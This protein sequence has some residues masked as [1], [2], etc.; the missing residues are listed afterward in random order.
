MK[1]QPLVYIFII[2]WN[3]KKISV[4]CLSS[5]FKI[6]QYSN[7]KVI[8]IDNGS[9]DDS[10]QDILKLKLDIEIM[11]NKENIGYAPAINA[12]WRYCLDKYNP[13]YVCNMN[14]DIIITQKEWLDLMV[15]SLEK[16]KEYGIC[17]NR[18]LF[19]D[20]RDQLLF[21]EL[22]FD[23]TD[24]KD[25]KIE[26]EVKS[27][28]GT[29]MLI[30]KSVINKIGGLDENSF[31]G[32]DDLDYCL[33]A[34]KAGFKII[35]QG[36]SKLIHLSSY[37]Y[38]NSKKDFIYSHQSYAQMLFTF[39]YGTFTE[40]LRMPFTQF[41]RIFI[42]RKI[43]FEKRTIKNTAFHLNFIKRGYYFFRALFKSLR[44]YKTINQDNF[45]KKQKPK[46]I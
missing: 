8:L 1:K 14:N 10:L 45:N 43:P 4:D 34:G 5:L 25:P 44:D 42:T 21:T 18:F 3:G 46:D 15:N 13:D 24:N 12:C 6:T 16:N 26:K 37:S 32:A 33:R 23:K 40:K 9:T 30:K 17:G 38:R 2:N 27:V 22:D 28:S 19:P 41:V 20:G 36:K 11:K 35:Y 29:N 39:R 7:F 31:C